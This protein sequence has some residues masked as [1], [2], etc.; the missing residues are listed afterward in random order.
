MPDTLAEWRYSTLDRVHHIGYTVHT[1]RTHHTITTRS[2]PMH[3]IYLIGFI[4][5]A[6]LILLPVLT[7]DRAPAKRYERIYTQTSWWRR[8]RIAHGD[9]CPNV[10]WNE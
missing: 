5:L 7:R 8:C 9:V 3:Y 1:L 4:T 2:T 10:D 6:L